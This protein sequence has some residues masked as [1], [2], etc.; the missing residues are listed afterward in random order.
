LAGTGLA[1]LEVAAQVSVIDGELASD[2]PLDLW[3]STHV[4][5]LD[6]PHG[7]PLFAVGARLAASTQQLR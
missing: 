1:G 6:D 5:G 4:E 3:R 2:D 7:R